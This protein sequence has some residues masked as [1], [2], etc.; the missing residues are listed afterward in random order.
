M[1][2]A[3][4]ALE[5]SCEAPSRTPVEVQPRPEQVRVGL[6]TSERPWA[7][8]NAQTD[9]NI[10]PREQLTFPFASEFVRAGE[11]GGGGGGG[12]DGGGGGYGAI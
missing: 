5:Q 12:G 1:L 10:S 4:A 7:Q 8:A 3:G 2:F 11:H 9:P 6:P